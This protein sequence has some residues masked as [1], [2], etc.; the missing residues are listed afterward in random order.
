M[1]TGFWNDVA[2]VLSPLAGLGK[3]VFWCVFPSNKLQGHFQ[4]SLRDALFNFADD[5]ALETPGYFQASLRDS[6]FANVH[7]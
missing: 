6:P 2:P 1:T 7:V 4:P 5:P 3:K